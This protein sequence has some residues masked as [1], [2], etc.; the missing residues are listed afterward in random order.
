MPQALVPADAGKAGLARP[1]VTFGTLT[2]ALYCVP[3]ASQVRCAH[4]LF[5]SDSDLGGTSCVLPLFTDE[6][7]EAQGG[8]ITGTHSHVSKWWSRSSLWPQNAL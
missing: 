4:Y 1:S 6:E 3:A 7:T 8:K 5:S 2:D